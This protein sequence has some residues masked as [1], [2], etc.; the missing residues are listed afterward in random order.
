MRG[1]A[2]ILGL[3]PL[4]LANEGRFVIICPGEKAKEVILFLRKY[5]ISETAQK[6]GDITHVLTPGK[7][8]LTTEYGSR[9]IIDMPSG[10]QLPRIC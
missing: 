3:D 1:A 2:E 8:V 7:V 10:E 6:I 5:E 9:R 4:Y